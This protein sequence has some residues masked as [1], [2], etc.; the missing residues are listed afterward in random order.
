MALCSSALS[1]QTITGRVVDAKSG[2]P[3]IGATIKLVGTDVG[4]I[5]D[6]DGY[7]TL[8][9]RTSGTSY[10][11]ISYIGYQAESVPVT[12]KNGDKNRTVNVS[13]T[14]QQQELKEVVVSAGRFEQDLN[15]VT[16]SMEVMKANDLQ[17]KSPGDVQDA[18][19][20]LSGVD[21]VDK[22]P[23][24]R[25]GGGWTYS[26][27]SRS[28]VLLDG[29]SVLNPKTGE[30]NW[31]TVPMENIAQVEVIKGASSVLYGSSALNG[32]I[33]ILTDRPSET[34]QTRI[35][36]Y[37]GVY[38]KYKTSAYNYG[39]YPMYKG[40][41]FSH[42]RRLL[43]D[44][45]LDMVL[46][47]NIYKDDG[48]KEQGDNKRLHASAS[49]EYHQPMPAGVYMDY[50]GKV[51]YLGNEYG[52]FF[53]WRSPLEANRPSPVTNLGRKEHMIDIAPQFNYTNTN[54]GISHKVRARVSMLFDR[55]TAPSQNADVLSIAKNAGVS[56]KFINNLTT[57][58]EKAYNKD[59]KTFNLQEFE[60]GATA[61]ELSALG[62]WKEL[63][64]LIN[65]F[66]S[67]EMP[68]DL[69]CAEGLYGLTNVLGYATPGLTTTDV[70]DIAGIALNALSGGSSPYDQCYSA[71][72]D[73][74]F[75]KE[76]KSGA[77]I[78]AGATWNHIQNKSY[79][80]GE[81]ASDNVAAYLQYDQ[82]FFNRLSVS[83][84]ARFEYY[85]ID[86]SYK[87]AS[88]AIGKATLP[89]RP[90]L[91]AGLNYQ[92][93]KATFL[94]LSVGQGYR[95]P[96]ITEKFVRKDIGGVGAYPNPNLKPESGINIELG[97]KQGVKVGNWHGFFDAAGFYNEY[98]DMIEFNFG[99]FDNTTY[100]PLTTTDAA[101][102]IILDL[103]NGQSAGIGIGAQFTNVSH[104][105]IYGAELEHVG[106]WD[107]FR[108]SKLRY[109]I[110]YLFTE[111]TDV[112]YKERN[113]REASYTGFQ[114][115]ETSN[116]SKYLK[117]RNKHTV[118]IALDYSWKWFSVGGNFTWKSKMLAVDYL[119]V[120]ERDKGTDELGNSKKD[121]MDYFREI[122][123]GN[124]KACDV[125]NPTATR[126]TLADHWKSMN[127]PYCVLDLHMGFEATKWLG[128]QLQ[129][130]NVLGTEYSYR[131][132]AIA[133]PRTYVAKLNFK[134]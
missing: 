68:T 127:R 109:S 130:N 26:V 74:Q 47:G 9:G 39:N 57:D 53:M 107:M 10:L 78:T 24:I 95:N 100:E 51:S 56:D 62:G 36:P 50:G 60:Y 129:V 84:G 55:T 122:L 3:L 23:S 104:A 61:T 43:Q 7:Y 45:S 90:V 72:L 34:P 12:F 6:I 73:Y 94:R 134:F 35:S 89:I 103:L 118:K 48:Y 92:A 125:F 4:T 77:R 42:T 25:G 70:I 5:T 15:H 28:Q 19:R 65:K 91:R 121:L 132:M 49:L 8:Q 46:A 29:M 120:D 106:E 114:M 20:T 133:A 126:Y 11:A 99:L 131:P 18:L 80:T 79:T 124:E 96:S 1:A 123:F 115:K 63:I 30:V 87:E 16:V 105:R 2:E 108:D 75:A 76:W 69:E 33:N 81:H 86:D 32:V 21:I 85:R 27:G 52:D 58:F 88:L 22:Q 54:T 101:K 14:E 98:W 110:S 113:E 93:A 59:T 17:T 102:Q 128:I 44:K 41:D 111:P 38:G 97:V 40:V 64:N 116:N 67:K 31:N 119:L 37:I 82:R 117:Y 83:A 66:S 71:Y 112:N 13:L